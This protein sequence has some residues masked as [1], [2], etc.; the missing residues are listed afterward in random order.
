MGERER[1][2]FRQRGRDSQRGGQERKRG[3]TLRGRRRER[4]G[5]E[6]TLSNRR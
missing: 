4:L 2:R 3:S 6:E 5:D 1:E